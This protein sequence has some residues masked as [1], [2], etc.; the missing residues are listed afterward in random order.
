MTP[1]SAFICVYLRFTIC[2]Y[3]KTYGQ[4]FTSISVHLRFAGISLM[5]PQNPLESVIFNHFTG[6]MTLFS[7]IVNHFLSLPSAQL[8]YNDFAN[9]F[10][11]IITDFG[12]VQSVEI[13]ELDN[14][15]S[16]P[17]ARKLNTRQ[18]SFPL[19][20]PYKAAGIKGQKKL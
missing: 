2:K 14:G 11:L 7:L 20:P 13:T 3:L 16:V 1:P 8:A 18:I 10:F 4:V 19:L 9:R 17:E 5:Q 15:S 12:R 6:K